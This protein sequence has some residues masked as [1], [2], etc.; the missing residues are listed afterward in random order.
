LAVGLFAD[1]SVSP[2]A[3]V[4][5]PGLLMGGGLSQLLPQFYGVLGTAAYVF[6]A[7][8]LS[9]WIIKQVVGMR[10]TPEEE[11]EGLDM[12]EHGNVAYPDFHPADTE[13]LG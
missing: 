13:L 2:A 7:S 9:F 1:P 8:L 10:V 12:G 4:V 11:L 5:K 3:A 6:P